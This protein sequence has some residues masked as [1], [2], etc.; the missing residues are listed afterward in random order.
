MS[1]FFKTLAVIFIFVLLF[2]CCKQGTALISKQSVRQL[3]AQEENLVTSDNLFGIKLFKKIVGLESEKNI[4]ISPLSISMAPGMTLNGAAGKT[5][6]AMENTLKL[7]GLNQKE[8]N[9]S[10]K[11]LIELL[12]NLD[13]KVIFHLANSIWYREG[14]DFKQEFIC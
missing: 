1:H 9:E 13:P 11:S 2:Q 14:L 6:E 12:R 7:Q 10:Y 5:R 4:F 8:I 3:T